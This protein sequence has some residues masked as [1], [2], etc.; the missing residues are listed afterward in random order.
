MEG[1][2]QDRMRDPFPEPPSDQWARAKRGSPMSVIVTDAGFGPDNWDANFETLETLPANDCNGLTLDLSP[3]FEPSELADRLHCFA[4][5]RIDFPSFADGRG[6]TIAR[7]L[8]LM[9]FRGRL[10]AAGHVLADQY[11]MVRRSGFNEVE[12]SNDL[13]A[14]QPETQWLFRANWREN[15]YQ[16][17]LRG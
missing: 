3:D 11:T 1:F 4:L 6:L 17:R 15:D 5:I 14:R 10:R 12:I 13:A 16:S 2:P 9:G 8:R 7:R